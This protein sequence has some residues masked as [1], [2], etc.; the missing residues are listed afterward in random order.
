MR[1]FIRWFFVGVCTP[2]NIPNT[3]TRRLIIFSLYANMVGQMY[4][5]HRAM[6]AE[7]E[8]M[9]LT[10]EELQAYIPPVVKLTNATDTWKDD[11]SYGVSR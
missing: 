8:L 4:W 9:E 3:R 2:E 10:N 5:Q 11:R 6:R 7:N 1:K